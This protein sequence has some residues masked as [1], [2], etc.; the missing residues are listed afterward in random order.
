MASSRTPLQLVQ[1]QLCIHRMTAFSRLARNRSL[2]ST[3]DLYQISSS[4]ILLM[5]DCLTLAHMQGPHG[6]VRIHVDEVLQAPD[7][8]HVHVIAPVLVGFSIQ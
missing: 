3:S 4:I 7:Q 6:P 5:Q 8:V 2:L 1:K